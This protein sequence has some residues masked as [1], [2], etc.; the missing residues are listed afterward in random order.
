MFGAH[1]PNHEDESEYVTISNADVN[2]LL[3]DC[4]NPENP[5]VKKSKRMPLGSLRC[6]KCVQDRVNQI[7]KVR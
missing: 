3:T 6:Y 7:D 4:G 1:I 2:L 5:E